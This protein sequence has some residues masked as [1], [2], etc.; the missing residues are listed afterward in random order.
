[1][2]FITSIA[3]W[4]LKK[5][6]NL[7]GEIYAQGADEAALFVE[8]QFVICQI[9]NIATQEQLRQRSFVFSEMALP[10]VFYQLLLF[11]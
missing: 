7:K 11:K 4:L 3:G 2:H 8:G 5:S 9:F 6:R 1:M 10:A